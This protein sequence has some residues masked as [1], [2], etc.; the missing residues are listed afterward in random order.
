MSGIPRGMQPL[1]LHRHRFPE[2]RALQPR[3][4]TRR[5]GRLIH[6]VED[7]RDGREV[8]RTENLRVFK[9]AQGVACEVADAAASGDNAEFVTSLEGCF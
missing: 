7:S 3:H 8:V 5:H 4:V 1:Q 9:K 6:A 2:Q